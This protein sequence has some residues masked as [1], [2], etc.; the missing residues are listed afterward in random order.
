MI[1]LY[2]R[3]VPFPETGEDGQERLGNRNVVIIG[4]GARLRFISQEPYT[5]LRQRVL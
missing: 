3:Q 5:G 2:S 1:N 4:G